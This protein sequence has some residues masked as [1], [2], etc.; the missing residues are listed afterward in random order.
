MRTGP[1]RARD[2]VV[3]RGVD[4]DGGGGLMTEKMVEY[5]AR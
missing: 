5:T 4:G 2:R 3:L 1:V